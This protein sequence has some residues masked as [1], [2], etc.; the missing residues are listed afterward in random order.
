[1]HTTLTFLQFAKT[2]ISSPQRTRRDWGLEAAVSA[3]AASKSCKKSVW[4]KGHTAQ[5]QGLA[6]Y[7][8]KTFQM[9]G[10]LKRLDAGDE[11]DAATAQSL[12]NTMTSTKFK[13]L[14]V[15]EDDDLENLI[16][17]HSA[18]ATPERM[19]KLRNFFRAEGSVKVSATRAAILKNISGTRVGAMFVRHNVEPDWPALEGLSA[20]LAPCCENVTA[21]LPLASKL[22]DSQL[23]AQLGV[24]D[25]LVSSIRA[26]VSFATAFDSVR[27]LM[28]PQ[29]KNFDET[30]LKPLAAV[31][32][33]MNMCPTF[34]IDHAGSASLCFVF[35]LTVDPIFGLLNIVHVSA[36]HGESERRH[37][38]GQLLCERH[39]RG[40]FRDPSP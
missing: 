19:A 7:Q 12:H 4:L 33:Q 10:Q 36:N 22:A 17:L 1:M 24:I 3:L 31:L 28:D 39:Q 38:L 30:F 5:I 6:Q 16:K 21:L 25:V 18:L 13:E 14:E 35:A 8:L 32:R 9:R 23:K 26:A 20:G 15:Y 37:A 27:K 34:Y 2:L 40:R 11:L 29:C